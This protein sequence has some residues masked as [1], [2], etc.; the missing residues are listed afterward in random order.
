[1]I[2][3]LASAFQETFGF[4]RILTFV[5]FRTALSVLTAMAICFVFG[6]L[7]IRK[8]QALQVGQ[9]IR[10]EGPEWHKP[11]AGT[12]TMGGILILCAIIVPTLLWADLTVPY[13]WVLLVSLVAFGAIGFADDLLK[14]R[15]GTNKGL[16]ARQKIL[17]Q[18]L[19]ALLV[20]IT[21]FSFS[22]ETEEP[23]P[24]GQFNTKL[25]IPFTKQMNVEIKEDDGN[26]VSVV[27]ESFLEM[28]WFFLPFVVIV[29]VGASNAVNLTD[30]LDGLAIGATG[31]ASATYTL[32]AYLAGNI[33]IAT[34]LLIPFIRGADEITI[35]GGALFGASLGFLWW[36]CFPASVF[37]GDVGSLSL[38]S[39]IGTMAVI[40]KQELLLV[41]VG[42][43]FV[44]E[45]LSVI[46]Q[47][48]YYRLS[49]G[50]RIFK[51]APLHHHFELKGW[52]EPKVITR[53]MILAIIFAMVGL[54]SL[55]IR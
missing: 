32:L 51:M 49:G 6:P 18:V 2:Y 7:I 29:I 46:L 38:G 53:F 36:N 8:L 5:N 43:L 52:S 50:K 40:I 31:I 25:T 10:E 55:K 26:R 34:Y 21:L 16:R 35:F 45:A 4:L 39:A 54:S 12:P 20:G 11:K 37:M 19:A 22:Q 42:G 17:M 47:V 48:A 28:G 23:A 44:I 41:L 24:R 33:S 15:S 30:G 9:S 13:I 1:M 3:H 27:E 14:I